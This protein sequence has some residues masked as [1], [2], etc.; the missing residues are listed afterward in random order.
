MRVVRFPPSLRALAAVV[1]LGGC[2]GGTG[3]GLDA[4]GRPIGGVAALFEDWLDVRRASNRITSPR[5][6]DG[7]R[8]DMARW[9]KIVKESGAKVD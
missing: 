8:D 9:G 6:V 1:A 3:E 2:G 4:S 7:Y 5:T